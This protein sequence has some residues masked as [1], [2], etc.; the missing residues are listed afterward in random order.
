MITI[1]VKSVGIKQI[2]DEI[3]KGLKGT[4]KNEFGEQTLHFDNKI[5][6]GSIRI[7]GFDWGISLLDYNVLFYEDVKMVFEISG[8]SPIEFLFISEG[9]LKYSPNGKFVDLER[10]QNVILSNKTNAENSFLFPANELIKVNFIQIIKQEY[11]KKTN[12]NINSLQDS[13]LSIFR[14]DNPDVAFQ[15]LGNYNI[16]IADY[17][18][19]L[20]ACSETGMIK[21]LTIEGQLNLI[22]AMQLLEHRNYE[23]RTVLP[24]S[25][26]KSD[27][28]QIHKL[29]D[30]IIDNISS[31]LS[32]EVLSRESGLS[33]K[34]LQLGFQLLYNKSVNEYVRKLKLELA[35]DL[36][37]DF[38]M[39]ISEIVYAIGYKSRSYFSKRF[40]EYYGIL[41]TEYRSQLKNKFKANIID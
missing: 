38:D 36:L 39:N 32:I 37:K 31:P 9:N 23:N 25:L 3:N 11:R 1:F 22:L 26:S 34:R 40:F 27:L 10:F 15:H 6:K 21:S 28:K 19:D 14:M 20:N 29:A 13:I 7:I 30:Y 16:R 35:R 41:P 4:I 12:N 8:N 2:I 5:G 17:I 33:P 24:D 18:K